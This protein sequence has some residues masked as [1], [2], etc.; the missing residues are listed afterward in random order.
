MKKLM[1]MLSAAAVAFGAFAAN[2]LPSGTSFDGWTVGG[3]TP[4]SADTGLWSAGF[5]KTVV[6]DAAY[7]FSQ[8]EKAQGGIPAQWAETVKEN[9]HL[10]FLKI[11]TSLTAPLYRS[12]GAEAEALDGLY[13]DSNVHFTA[14]DS[15]PELPGDAHAKLAVWLKDMTEAD[16]AEA[17]TNLM[18]TAGCYSDKDNTLISKT[19]NCGNIS[20]FSIVD[21]DDWC[22]LTIKALKTSN[23]TYGFVVFVN[24]IAVQHANADVI[25]VEGSV[26]ENFTDIAKAYN[27]RKQLFPSMSDVNAAEISQVGFAGQGGVDNISFTRTAPAF[28][29]GFSFVNVTWGEGVTGFYCGTQP[30]PLFEK[31]DITAA[32]NETFTLDGTPTF[33][34]TDI[35]AT[36]AD[37]V[38]P[39]TITKENLNVTI[40]T[41][42]VGATV[43]IGGETQKF[44]TAAD[45]VKAINDKT[46]EAPFNA[47]LALGA[48]AVAGIEIKNA[49]ANVVLDLAGNDI[50]VGEGN[51]ITVTLG[52][53]FITNSTETVGAVTTGE[54]Y[55]VVDGEDADGTSISAGIFNGIVGI[56]GDITGGKFSYAENKTE[57]DE[58]ALAAPEGFEFVKDNEEEPQYWVL[59]EAAKPVKPE[60]INNFGV[61]VGETEN[62]FTFTA[63]AGFAVDVYAADGT[64]IEAGATSYDYS[65]IFEASTIILVTKMIPATATAWW[66][67]PKAS[68]LV[69][70]LPLDGAGKVSAF[71]GTGCDEFLGLTYGTANIGYQLFKLDGTSLQSLPF[72]DVPEEYKPFKTDSTTEYSVSI[73]RGV[74]M[75]KLLNVA[76]IGS[77]AAANEMF[78][79]PL[80]ATTLTFG[81]GGNVKCIN[82]TD[83]FD[84][85]A[86][87]PDGKYLFSNSM[88]GKKK[89]VKWAVDF[90]QENPFTKVAELDDVGTRIR[91][92]TYAKI[93][94]KDYV[95]A[96]SDG[97]SATEIICVDAT[98]NESASWTKTTLVSDLPAG[99]YGSLCVSGTTTKHLTVA[100]SINNDNS[101]DVLAV[102]TIAVTEDGVTATQAAK[103]TQ[104]QL[105]ARGFGDQAIINYGNAVYVTEDESAIYFA[106]GDGKI[107]KAVNSADSLA[108]LAVTATAKAKKD[109]AIELSDVTLEVTE[110]GVTTTDFTATL[111]GV[112]TNENDKATVYVESTATGKFGWAKTALVIEKSAEPKLPGEPVVVDPKDADAKVDEMNNNKADYL[113]A[114]EGVEFGDGEF[115]NYAKLFTA[116]PNASRTEIAFLLN[117]DG[118]KA[119]ADAE[120]A[121]KSPIL[122]AIA[123]AEGDS[124]ELKIETP[125]KGFYYGL[126]QAGELKSMAIDQVM[127]GGAEEV[128]FSLDK[129]GA[130]G[131]Y[132]MIVSPTELKVENK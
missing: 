34:A 90:T 13:Y 84:G 121:E 105:F 111:V 75:S 22:R 2:A 56:Y 72:A 113:K 14:C 131:F 47:T 42:S 120:A 129:S 87:S 45:A 33:A 81:D 78:A 36:Y 124:A 57:D 54:G 82:P 119:V 46:A 55:A 67:N 37:D 73:L 6:S 123:A 80:N 76:L 30:K 1:I 10:N 23:S 43:T 38:V 106:R 69:S 3:T 93:G 64:L 88:S 59:K 24:G 107:Y 17:F 109:A 41:A 27:N 60:I 101:G 122:A 62:G 35:H 66:T 112:A 68:V 39:G 74:A 125:I 21:G 102:Y 116:T 20:Q 98:A 25:G 108:D 97:T 99:S 126:K 100:P 31:K 12:V 70:G 61:T 128:K 103:F 49:N 79:V 65:E 114:P 32:G 4:D 117:A 83:G 29:T 11:H 127:L 115:A 7:T 92:M 19:Y 8:E 89:I 118:E 48:D 26:V 15:D 52:T 9:G 16:P 28:D 96:M 95:F 63:P 18:I 85:A 71:H 77:Y 53:L 5:D 91:N 86:F 132:E 110:G 51:A 40:P 104:A 94:G 44:A 58:C 130:A 50:T